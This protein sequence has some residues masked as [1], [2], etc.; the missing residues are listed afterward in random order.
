MEMMEEK[1]T[2]QIQISKLQGYLQ[3]EAVFSLPTSMSSSP[4]CAELC[5]PTTETPLAV[6]DP[7]FSKVGET[8]VV[9][10]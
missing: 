10:D 2:L 8:L 7:L 1:D 4:D 5:N 9:I 6:N 3:E